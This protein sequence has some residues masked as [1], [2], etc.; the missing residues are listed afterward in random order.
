[1]LEK[2]QKKIDQV[3]FP[4]SQTDDFRAAHASD[5]GGFELRDEEILGKHRS[6]IKEM[7]TV[8]ERAWSDPPM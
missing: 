5:N 1:M 2:V 7:I 6:V 4:F 8:S 3:T